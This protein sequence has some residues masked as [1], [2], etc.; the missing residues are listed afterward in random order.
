MRCS[1]LDYAVS[2]GAR[3][4]CDAGGHRLIASGLGGEDAR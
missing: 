2:L 1:G 4:V 3:P